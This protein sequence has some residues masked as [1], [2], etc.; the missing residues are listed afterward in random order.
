MSQFYGTVIGQAKTEATRGS[1]NSGLTTMCNGWNSG[2]KVTAHM[3]GETEVF[4][5]W[6]TSGSNGNKSSEFIATVKYIDGVR[7]VIDPDHN[8]MAY[9]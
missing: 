6:L 4:T 8:A 5:I 1:K 9:K 2:V 7:T 3:D